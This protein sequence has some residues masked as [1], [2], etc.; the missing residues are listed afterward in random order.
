MLQVLILKHH[1]LLNLFKVLFSLTLKFVQIITIFKIQAMNLR[2][3]IMS[4]SDT[5]V[6]VTGKHD[7]VKRVASG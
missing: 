4:I 3:H 1:Y 7:D 2:Q 5:P 6:L